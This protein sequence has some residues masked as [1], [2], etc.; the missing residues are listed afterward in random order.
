MRRLVAIGGVSVAAIIGLASPAFADD[1]AN[2][3]RKTDNVAPFTER[4]RWIMI[5]TGD[6]LV[7]DIWAFDMPGE[8]AVLLDGSHACT[9]TRLN[10]QTKKDP[11]PQGIWSEECF[12]EAFGG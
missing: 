10:A 12:E 3:S 8:D 11:E 1:C 7:G 5:P 6:P 4:G 9:S 2:L